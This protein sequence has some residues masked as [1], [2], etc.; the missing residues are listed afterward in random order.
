[1]EQ[2]FRCEGCLLRRDAHHSISQTV[3]IGH[4]NAAGDRTYDTNKTRVRT[5]PEQIR[6]MSRSVTSLL[7]AINGSVVMPSETTDLIP[8]RFDRRMTIHE[9]PSLDLSRFTRRTPPNRSNATPSRSSLAAPFRVARSRP[10][11]QPSGGDRLR[12]VGPVRTGCLRCRR[13]RVAGPP[14]A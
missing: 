12:Q 4:R 3:L 14:T 9:P 5:T 2:V 13:R 11:R 6:D 1:M 10:V 7:A 8:S